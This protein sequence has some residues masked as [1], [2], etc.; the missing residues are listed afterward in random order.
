MPARTKP[1]LL[2]RLD[3]GAESF[4]REL[5]REHY[6]NGAGLKDELSLTPIFERHAWMFER[7]LV[8][9]LQRMKPS[10]ERYPALRAFVVEAYLEH[11]VKDM[12]EQLASRE[13]N[14]TIEWDKK[15]IAYRAIASLI[16]NESNPER[17]RQLDSLRAELTADQNPLRESRL[18]EL[19][20]AAASL[21]YPTYV[22]LCDDVGRLH[23]QD[24]REMAEDFL[25]TT[26][27]TYRDRLEGYLRDG[28]IVPARAEKCDL[29]FL[30]RAARYD[31]LFPREGLLP[32]LETTLAGLGIS[33]ANQANVHLDTDVRPRKSPRAFCSA[34][35]VP[36]EIMLVVNPQGGQDDYQALLHEAGHTEHFANVPAELPYAFRGLGD[37]SVTEGFAFLVQHLTRNRSWLRDVLQ[38]PDPDAF[39]AF[40]IFYELYMLRRYCTKLLYE[41]ELHSVEN[42]RAKSKRY[43]DLLTANLGVRYSPVDYLF[44]VDDG[45]YAARYLRAWIFEAQVRHKLEERFGAEWF[46][47]AEGGSL[48]REWWSHGQRYTVEGLLQRVGYGGL[49]MAIL[50]DELVG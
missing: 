25:V 4:A 18:E 36:G 44:D 17:R 38:V 43:A 30:F 24:L 21:G 10:D 14:D 40:N 37:N 5:S 23:L 13:T 1:S 50:R 7:R 22:D 46:T 9:E 28:G 26:D 8:D 42:P 34:I 41:L 48:V 31:G 12:S 16:A 2:D 33:L 20:R 19:H 49:D 15:A 45:F 29:S 39:V 27:S 11:A 47:T 3:E 6:L 32:A 35:D